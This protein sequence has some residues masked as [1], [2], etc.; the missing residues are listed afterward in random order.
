MVLVVATILLRDAHM[1]QPRFFMRQLE[2]QRFMHFCF[3]SKRTLSVK[4]CVVVVVITVC[5]LVFHG[6]GPQCRTWFLS[7]SEF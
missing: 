3:G 1:L 4:H 5:G 7:T 6:A 2:Q